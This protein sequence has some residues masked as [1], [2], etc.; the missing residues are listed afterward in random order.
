M[1]DDSGRWVEVTGSQFP[2]EAD[3]LDIVR[4]L[5]PGESPFRAWS[6]FEFR[7]SHG[8]WPELD[9]LVLARDGFHLV[10]LK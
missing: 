8:R 5:L 1:A 10:E 9:L 4:R 2:H 3:G 6:N 7:D